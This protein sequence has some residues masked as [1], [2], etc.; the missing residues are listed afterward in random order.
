MTNPQT[1]PA[2]PECDH[3]SAGVGPVGRRL[4]RRSL[5][6]AV[7]AAVAAP[8]VG[9]TN[10]ASGDASPGSP[11]ALTYG[12]W[13][14][15]FKPGLEKVIA[16][17]NKVEPDITVDVQPI[18]GDEYWTKMQ[19]AATAGTA[20]DVFWMNEPHFLEYAIHDQLT[21]LSE[22]IEADGVDVSKFPPGLIEAY[23][24]DGEQ[25]ALPWITAMVGLWYNKSLFDRHRV[26]YPDDSW[27]WDSVRDAAAELTDKGSGVYGIAA[28]MSNQLNYYNTILQAGGFIISDDLK[29]SGFGEPEGVEGIQFWVDFIENGTSPTH[30]Q[31]TDTDPSQL[32]QS[33]KLGMFYGGSWD[34]GTFSEVDAI[35]DTVA[36]AEL[37]RGKQR[38]TTVQGASNVIYAKSAHPGEAWKLVKF[39]ESEQAQTIQAET[40]IVLPAYAGTQEP[41]VQSVPEYDLGNLV[42]QLEYASPYPHSQNTAAWQTEQTKCLTPAWTLKEDVGTACRKLADAMNAVLAEEK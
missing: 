18:T 24:V 9:C 22:L 6:A 27:T 3:V 5:L 12:I 36:V 15:A 11:V 23:Q 19:A 41:W 17:F 26:G 8:L 31:M 33:G 29:Q 21:P 39:L 25:Y 2:T 4:A 42:D 7:P 16:E 14:A 10:R 38:G 13:D 35:A 37:P 1:E 28:A 32:F 40:G 34:A 30:Q 20:P